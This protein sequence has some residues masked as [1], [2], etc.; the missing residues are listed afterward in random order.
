MNVGIPRFA[1]EQQ[2][3]ISVFDLAQGKKIAPLLNSRFH[4]SWGAFSPDGKWFAFA[5]NESG[6]NEVT[7]SSSIIQ[8]RLRHTSHPYSLLRRSDAGSSR[9]A[10]M[11]RNA[12]ERVS[13]LSARL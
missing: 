7:L 8:S 3:D 13:S 10:K 6:S 9:M 1:N 4:E 12:T 5:S 2:S 11:V